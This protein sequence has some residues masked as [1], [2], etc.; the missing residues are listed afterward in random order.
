MPPKSEHIPNPPGDSVDAVRSM[1]ASDQQRLL[2][3]HGRQALEL[4]PKE[5]I[6]DRTVL[7]DGESTSTIPDAIVAAMGRTTLRLIDALPKGDRHLA[8]QTGNFLELVGVVMPGEDTATLWAE[9]HA[10]FG[11]PPAKESAEDIATQLE[12]GDKLLAVI[13]ANRTTFLARA[14]HKRAR[15]NA[16][17]VNAAYKNASSKSTTLNN[18]AGHA[19]GYKSSDIAGPLY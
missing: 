12:M 7:I 6:L 4:G 15:E 13:S 5:V 9:A 11:M 10:K 16:A 8:R 18:N 14:H 3:S 17:N 1:S 19:P 2:E